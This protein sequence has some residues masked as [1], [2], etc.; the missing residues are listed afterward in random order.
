MNVCSLTQ[1]SILICSS[2]PLGKQ[3]I[4]KLG[5]VMFCFVWEQLLVDLRPPLSE[6]FVVVFSYRVGGHSPFLRL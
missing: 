1:T 2:A 4:L 5:K 3:R 6:N